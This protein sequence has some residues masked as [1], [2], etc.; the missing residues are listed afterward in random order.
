M[1]TLISETTVHRREFPYI[2]KM[3]SLPAE[4]TGQEME[5]SL[6]NVL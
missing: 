1:G 2:G 5:G 3:D 4:S 6:P